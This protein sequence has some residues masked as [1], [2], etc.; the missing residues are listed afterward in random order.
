[1]V[2]P[3]AVAVHCQQPVTVAVELE[4]AHPLLAVMARL[5]QVVEV[6]EVV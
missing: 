5:T 2:V 4:Q 3:V 6:V 1:V